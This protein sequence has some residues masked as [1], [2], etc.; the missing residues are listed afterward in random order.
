M[1]DWPGNISVITA[2]ADDLDAAK[3]FY[4][5]VFGLTTIYQDDASAVYKFGNMMINLLTASQAPELIEPT[6]P[7]G[8]DAGPRH[9][10]TLD[11]DDVDAKAAELQQKGVTLLNGPQDRPWG[12]RTVAFADPTGTVWELSAPLKTAD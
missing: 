8:A 2:F 12:I 6:V 5:D 3:T 7:G 11:V 10:L 4:H 9:L 1:T